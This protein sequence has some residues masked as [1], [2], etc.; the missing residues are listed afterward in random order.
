MHKLPEEF[1]GKMTRCPK[2]GW[3]IWG[4]IHL[5]CVM[6]RKGQD[7]CVVCGKPVS[8]LKKLRSRR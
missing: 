2:C 8:I 3:S 4:N 1:P 5:T 6:G 7:N